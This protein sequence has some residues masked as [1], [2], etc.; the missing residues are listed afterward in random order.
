MH[1]GGGERADLVPGQAERY[2]VGLDL[3][4]GADRD[5]DVAP[6]PEVA[7]LEHDVRDVVAI[8][9][10]DGDHITHIV[11]ERG[12]FWGR[13]DVTIPISAVAE[14][15]TDVVALSL[16]RDEVGALPASRVHR[17]TR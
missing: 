12:H 6:P 7:A 13:R 15:K 3:R 9:V 11:L 16:T 8:D 2:D 17:W 5:R 14:V 1:A 4:D 10:V